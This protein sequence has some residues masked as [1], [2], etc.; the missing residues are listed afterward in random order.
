MVVTARFVT[1]EVHVVASVDVLGAD[2]TVETISGP[3]IH[4]VWFADLQEWV[5]LSVLQIWCQAHDE[6]T[7]CYLRGG[8]VHVRVNRN[9]LTGKLLFIIFR[10]T[11]SPKILSH[12][13]IA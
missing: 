13:K 11:S 10:R 8:R 5:P 3:T 12:S 1:H 4:A 7:S 9:C 2:G 6:R